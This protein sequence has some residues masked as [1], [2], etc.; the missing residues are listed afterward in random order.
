MMIVAKKT[1]FNDLHA[2]E[3]ANVVRKIIES[4]AASA[5]G[6][7]VIPIDKW[8]PL[9]LPG[10]IRTPEIPATLLPG[11]VGD[12]AAAVSAWSQTPQAMATMFSVSV[13]A[14]VLQRRVEIAPWN[15]EYREPL[16]LWTLT[17]GA[18]GTRKTAV[19]DALARPL[20]RWEKLERD[21]MR[22]EIARAWAAREVTNKRIEKLKMDGAKA[23]SAEKRQLIQ[24]EIQREREE[25]PAEI[26]APRIFTGDITG[27]RLQQLLVE[28]DER[29]T[30]LTDEAGIFGIMAGQ[31]SGGTAS[32]DVFLQGHSGTAMRVD[33]AGRLAHLDRPALSF[34]LALQPGMLMDAAKSGRFR[35]SGLLARFLYAIPKSNVGER[36]VRTHRTL[37][38]D[39]RDAWE[40]N[41]F[42]LLD[43]QQRP[44]GAPKILPLDDAARERW[45]EFS[46]YV[47][48][49]QGDGGC[50]AHM[51]DWTSKL[52]GAAA[53]I[54]AL[55]ELAVRGLS[56]DAVG[57]DSMRRSLDLCRL[58]A[59]HAEAAFR[60]MGTVD[61]EGDALALL[62]WIEANRL[63]EFTRHEAH[64]AME[65]RFRTVARLLSAI[66]TLQEWSALSPERQR[67]NPRARS[68]AFYLVSPRLF[69]DDSR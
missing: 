32:L 34:G 53:R 61:A 49:R 51:T 35:D 66:R 31:Y 26:Y 30:V 22:S 17:T 16:S 4:A 59:L 14:A 57:D 9:A 18:S 46:E 36:D 28:Q 45:L 68:T 29:M 23:E 33:R 37:P 3:G 10:A 48:R 42:A 63:T 21:R 40:R 7:T 62:R 41:L 52:P 47:E 27:E 65:G 60:L 6:A 67:R 38:A 1:D 12:M 43:G 11:W 56:A 20:I 50:W 69:V 58:L 55:L 44:V 54:S 39:I 64:K 15:D 24:A 13:L 8:P 2:T 25:M 5:V 19:I